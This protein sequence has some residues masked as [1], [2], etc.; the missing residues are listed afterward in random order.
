MNMD[1]T[2]HRSCCYGPLGVLVT[3]VTA[4]NMHLLAKRHQQ[5]F[6]PISSSDE[7]LR[8]DA[9]NA[10]QD[11]LANAVKS[12]IEAFRSTLNFEEAAVQIKL[13]FDVK[14]GSPWNCV[15]GRSVS[16]YVLT[17]SL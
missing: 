6:L 13:D 4:D 7:Q 11:M 1:K 12:S 3:K 15:V 9:R 2:F 8:I 14:F 10:T 5:G 17:H 16:G